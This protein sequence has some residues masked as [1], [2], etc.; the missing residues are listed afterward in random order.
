VEIELLPGAV[1]EA[2]AFLTDRPDVRERLDR[3]GNLIAGFE[4]PY[5]MEL[6][7]SVHWIACN[8]PNPATS[9]DAAVQKIAAWSDRKALMFKADHIKLAWNRLASQG[10]IPCSN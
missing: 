1:D 5:G 4:T 10:W 6:L 9:A 3:V 7:S 8:D 2:N